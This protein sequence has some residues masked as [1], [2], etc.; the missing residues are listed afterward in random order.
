MLR[1]F[2]HSMNQSF[3]YVTIEFLLSTSCRRTCSN[4]LRGRESRNQ[5]IKILR[6]SYI[7]SVIIVDKFD[8]RAPTKHEI[9][10]A[11]KHGSLLILHPSSIHCSLIV[12][13]QH[14]TITFSIIKL[15]D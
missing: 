11:E 6:N 15:K 9:K 8:K 4:G 1:A 10:Y 7:Q 13:V 14:T 12:N 5:K 2:K 3:S